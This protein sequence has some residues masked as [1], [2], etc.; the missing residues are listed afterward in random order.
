MLNPFVLV[1][2]K[3]Q[4]TFHSVLTPHCWQRGHHVCIYGTFELASFVHCSTKFTGFCGPREI[5]RQSHQRQSKCTV[6]SKRWKA[7]DVSRFLHIHTY[8]VQH[9]CHIEDTRRH[10]KR[11][12]I[13][14]C[15]QADCCVPA[16]R[17]HVSPIVFWSRSSGKHPSI[18]VYYW[19][20]VTYWV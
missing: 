12:S 10:T 9:V 19:F 14:G 2:L 4:I 3:D 11:D 5:W 8:G 7:I 1:S 20:L 18:V 15:H 13:G 16:R 6:F 17:F